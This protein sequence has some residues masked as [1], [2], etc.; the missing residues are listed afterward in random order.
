MKTFWHA[1]ISENAGCGWK[2]QEAECINVEN[3]EIS[4][5]DMSRVEE[6]LKL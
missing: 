3:V 4:S 6:G 5:S 1:E 2:S